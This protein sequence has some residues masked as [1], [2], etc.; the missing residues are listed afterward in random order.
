MSFRKGRKTYDNYD[1]SCGFGRV[2]V[3]KCKNTS[4]SSIRTHSLWMI[5]EK[6][7]GGGFKPKLAIIFYK[8]HIN[9]VVYK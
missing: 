9:I 6:I 3:Q 4:P 5:T 1:S 8:N 7:A 2:Y